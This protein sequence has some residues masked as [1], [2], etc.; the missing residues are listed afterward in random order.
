MPDN[1][2]KAIQNN[3]IP[4]SYSIIRVIY[5]NNEQTINE[6]GMVQ[7]HEGVYTP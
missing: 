2:K 7:S 5:P 1:I 4:V 6:S 3:L